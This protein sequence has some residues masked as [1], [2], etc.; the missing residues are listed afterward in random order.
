M[1][2]IRHY[3]LDGHKPI[4]VKDVM[5]WAI[6]FEKKDTRRFAYDEFGDVRVSTVFLGLDHRWGNG[7]PL[8]FETMVFGMDK[9]YG[10]RY[11]TWKQAEAGHK[12][13]VAMVKRKLRTKGK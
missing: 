7:P 12:R 10:T 4:P 13:T 5:Q 2:L 3:I 11:S 1:N 8:L 6:E 9:E